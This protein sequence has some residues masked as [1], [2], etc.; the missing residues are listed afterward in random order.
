MEV[1]IGSLAS[2]GLAIVTAIARKVT[3]SRFN[4]EDLKMLQELAEQTKPVLNGLAKSNLRDEELKTSLDHVVDALKSADKEVSRIKQMPF[5]SHTLRNLNVA[6]RLRK[7]TTRLIGALAVL[8]AG[9]FALSS[10]QQK[11]IDSLKDKLRTY[12]ECLEY[13]TE[14]KSANS[15]EKREQTKAIVFRSESGN[16]SQGKYVNET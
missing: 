10:R 8:G 9:S 1:T 2:A 14:S 12:P 16:N 15:D 6:S 5:G 7:A 11:E 4:C 3:Q 13:T